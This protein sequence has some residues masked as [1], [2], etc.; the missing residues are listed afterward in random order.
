MEDCPSSCSVRPG[1]LIRKM[2][3]ASVESRSPSKTVLPA[4]ASAPPTC[5]RSACMTIPS[6]AVLAGAAPAR[7]LQ[8][9]SLQICD[10]DSSRA[11]RKWPGEKPGQQSLDILSKYTL[12]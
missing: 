3:P 11:S 4:E 6:D 9:L 12:V 7:K 1:P 10:E 2:P 8:P 5:A